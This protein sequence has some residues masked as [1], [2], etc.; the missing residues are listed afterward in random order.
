M[1]SPCFY[2]RWLT[3][4]YNPTLFPNSAHA[5][6][7]INMMERADNQRLKDQLA[8]ILCAVCLLWIFVYISN[9]VKLVKGLQLGPGDGWVQVF[10]LTV[11]LVKRYLKYRHKTACII[12]DLYHFVRLDPRLFI[13]LPVVVNCITVVQKVPLPRLAWQ[14]YAGHATADLAGVCVPY[15]TCHS[16]CKCEK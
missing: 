7:Q 5:H 1:H 16:K 10:V 4:L 15:R 9:N 2:G 12:P 3:L 11:S 6:V 13:Q 8:N 14:V